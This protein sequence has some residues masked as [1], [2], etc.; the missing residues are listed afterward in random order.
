M[1]SSFR[2]ILPHSARF[3]MPLP[4]YLKATRNPIIFRKPWN[5][6]SA[7]CWLFAKPHFKHYVTNARHPIG[8]LRIIRTHARK[9]KVIKFLILEAWTFKKRKKS[10]LIKKNKDDRGCDKIRTNVTTEEVI[11][12][13]HLIRA[14]RSPFHI[15]EENNE[16]S[17][18]IF[19]RVYHKYFLSHIR[20]IN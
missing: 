16:I 20:I 8:Q 19:G 18:Q 6:T 3:C 9:R 17:N 11:N 10:F 4:R 2:K 13:V 5:S 12:Y 14:A 7:L 1:V 15:S